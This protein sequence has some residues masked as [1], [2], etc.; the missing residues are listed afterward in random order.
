MSHPVSVARV[1]GALGCASGRSK[2]LEII[3]LRH[4][5]TVLHRHNG[6][7]ALADEDRALLGAI[8]AAL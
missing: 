3:V 6:R 8:A 5:F 2:D 4:Q 7:P 1:V